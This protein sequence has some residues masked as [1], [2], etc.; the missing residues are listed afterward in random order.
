MRSRHIPKDI[1]IAVKEQHFFECAW[2]GQ[3]LIE[4]HHIVD[5]SKGGE[6]SVGNLILLCPTCHTQVHRNEI[7]HEE[8]MNRKSTH[9]KGEHIS[10]AS[11]LI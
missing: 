2:C 1:D 10:A 8:L 4:R 11:T 9:I 7:S 3:K 5:F 6:H